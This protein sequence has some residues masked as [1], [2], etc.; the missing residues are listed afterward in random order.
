MRV[1]CDLPYFVDPSDIR[2]FAE[3]AEE[4]GYDHL[5]F[6]EHWAASRH[7]DVPPG[8]AFDDPWHESATMLGFLAAVTS[9]IELVPSMYLVTLRSPVLAAKQ[10]AEV[11]LLSGGRLRACVSAG[12][13]RE[14]QVALGVDPRTRGRRLEET[15]T[16][17]RRLWA[18]EAVTHHGDLF[19]L[20]EV[21]IHPRPG[22]TIPIWTGAGEVTKQG[23]PPPIALERAA[24]LADGFKLM[25]PT[26]VNAGKSIAVAERLHALAARAGRTIEVE[27]RLLTQVTP[28]EE[29]AGHVRRY[30]ESGLISHV[31]LGNRILGGDVHHQIAL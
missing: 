9:R 15:I 26:G 31:G 25:A 13:N 14:E 17:L 12:W 19:D 5:G 3:A 10:L 18:D 8:F 29:W 1:G 2:A 24:R 28:K 6:S 11:D 27:A 16:L 4:A 21:G 20:D 30:R 23:E 7:T 22:R